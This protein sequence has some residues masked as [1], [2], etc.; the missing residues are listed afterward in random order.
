MEEQVVRGCDDWATKND[1][2][3]VAYF[4][5]CREGLLAGI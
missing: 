2:G 3:Y 1:D 4:E 5:I